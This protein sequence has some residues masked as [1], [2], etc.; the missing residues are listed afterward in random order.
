M[1][2]GELGQPEGTAADVSDVRQQRR[3]CTGMCLVLELKR[4]L[5]AAYNIRAAALKEFVPGVKRCGPAGHWTTLAPLLGRPTS[6]SDWPS[7]SDDWPVAR[8]LYCVLLE[9]SCA[10][11]SASCE[12]HGASE[13]CSDR[14]DALLC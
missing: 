9:W 11:A 5:M 4:F 14:T 2:G 13:L 8:Y 1:Q 3:A 12:W 6:L 10:V 7:F